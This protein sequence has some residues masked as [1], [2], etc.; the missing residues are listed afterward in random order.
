MTVVTLRV[1][2]VKTA[3]FLVHTVALMW[4]VRKACV[5][6]MVGFTSLCPFKLMCC[7]YVTRETTENTAKLAVAGLTA[8][9]LGGISFDIDQIT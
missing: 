5:I 1:M 7:T 9:K 2:T 8:T 3:V 6:M 4:H